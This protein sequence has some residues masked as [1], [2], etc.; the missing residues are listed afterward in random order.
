MCFFSRGCT[1]FGSLQHSANSSVVF[2]DICIAVIPCMMF[3]KRYP[4]VCFDTFVTF[5]GWLARSKCF[6]C[7]FE[8]YNCL[9]MSLVICS[10][11]RH[12]AFVYD[13]VVLLARWIA[14]RLRT[15]FDT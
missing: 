2:T 3:A 5:R 14:Q 1:E 8:N 7:V 10:T 11:T 15:V 13:V 12:S 9:F 4:F 6:G